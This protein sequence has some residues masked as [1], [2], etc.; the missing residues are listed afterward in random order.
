MMAGAQLPASLTTAARKN[1]RKEDATNTETTPTLTAVSTVFDSS[2]I[3]TTG[4]V[5]SVEEQPEIGRMRLIVHR[6]LAIWVSLSDVLLS[7]AGPP[8]A[9]E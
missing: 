8:L 9:K 4:S 5:A 6:C 1:M 3:G 7:D 2:L